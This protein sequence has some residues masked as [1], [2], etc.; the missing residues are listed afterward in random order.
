MLKV[1]FPVLIRGCLQIVTPLERVTPRVLVQGLVQD[2]PSHGS[3][4]VVSCCFEEADVS[5]FGVPDNIVD[6]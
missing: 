5:D 4:D 1:I 6:A 2:D 3:R